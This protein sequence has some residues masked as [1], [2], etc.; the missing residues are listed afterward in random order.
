MC[1]VY[2]AL[3]QWNIL[4]FSTLL[5]IYLYGCMSM[6]SNTNKE[7]KKTAHNYMYLLVVQLYVHARN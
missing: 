3:L 1:S 2:A 4:D 6:S 7:K 5:S